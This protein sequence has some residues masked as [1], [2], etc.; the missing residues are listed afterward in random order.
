MK[1]YLVQHGQAKT[2]DED[3][4]RPLSDKGRAEVEKVVLHMKLD[5]SKII[6][7]KKLRAK[8]TAEILSSHLK[9][10]PT[11][12]S[13]HLDPMDNPKDMAKFIEGQKEDLMI[14]GHLPH[15]DKLSSLLLAG[16]PDAGVIKF[17]MGGIV[18]LEKDKEWRI[19]W[20]YTP[21]IV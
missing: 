18:C 7:S 10:V 5:I 4:E 3:P 1:L 11:E 9:N 20:I 13:E 12:E 15:L 19:D 21:D 8:Q 16:K 2:K 17:T 6:H 14:V